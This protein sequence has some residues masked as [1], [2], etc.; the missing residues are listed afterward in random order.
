MNGALP[1]ACRRVRQVVAVLAPG[2]PHLHSENLVPAV[3]PDGA[4][5]SEPDTV[6]AHREPE[7][8]P[9]DVVRQLRPPTARASSAFV[10][11]ERPFTPL[12]LASS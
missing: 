1:N 7:Q 4:D 5:G 6:G 12:S 2:A 10:I 9:G 3:H 11:F 8:L